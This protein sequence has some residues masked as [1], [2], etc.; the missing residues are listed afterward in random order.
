MLKLPI[1][2]DSR[3]L[4]KTALDL[5]FRFHHDASLSLP[6]RAPRR[7]LRKGLRTCPS[8]AT[9]ILVACLLAAT[10]ADAEGDKNSVQVSS[11]TVEAQLDTPVRLSR[12]KPGSI[13][14]GR[15]MRDVYSGERRV[16]P[17]GSRV[18][19][20]VGKLER[21]RR[22]HNDHWPWVVQVFARRHE[23]YPSF[24]SA[25]ISLPDGASIPVHVSLLSALH[26]T[27][28]R[29]RTK[30]APPPHEATPLLPKLLSIKRKVRQEMSGPA[31]ILGVDRP[32]GEDLPST[33]FA[34]N[35][36]NQAAPPLSGN[37]ALGTQARLILL[38][39]LSASK[40]RAGDVFQARLVEPVRWSSTAVL[41][42]GALYEGRVVKSVPPRR[43]SPPGSL[44]LAFTRLTLPTGEGAAIAAS[45]SG[46]EVDQ[47]SRL[48]MNSEGVM[49]GGSPGKAHLPI[50]VR[51]TGGESLRS[52]M[53]ACNLL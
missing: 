11:L 37:S 33:A 6:P 31:W 39:R 42:E 14:Q 38:T 43:L 2:G 23:N 20:T 48:R 9:L 47:R 3:V 46:A 5:S 52:R 29:A 41:P 50:D 8:T 16:F 40:N 51:V 4:E 53:T 49:S 36:F 10:F 22:E 18:R 15:I 34:E 1:P 27:E 24:Q 45:L 35:S 32:A 21:R 26:V 25:E 12:L 30:S 28:V 19:L 13:L 7:L 17:A 44:H